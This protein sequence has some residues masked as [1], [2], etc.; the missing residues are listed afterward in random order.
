MP[1]ST[2]CE[3]RNLLHANKTARK[4]NKKS[5]PNKEEKKNSKQYKKEKTGKRK[6]RRKS[7]RLSKNWR[8]WIARGRRPARRLK[9]QVLR[10]DIYKE[11]AF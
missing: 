4:E 11:R 9:T 8:R 1:G 7:K 5:A 6:K 3:I 2:S 10:K